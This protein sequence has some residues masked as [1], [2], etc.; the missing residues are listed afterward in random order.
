MAQN[1]FSSVYLKENSILTRS[2]F[3]NRNKNIIQNEIEKQI[4][5]V[6]FI[7]NNKSWYEFETEFSNFYWIRK[8]RWTMWEIEIRKGFNKIQKK[9]RYKNIPEEYIEYI[10]SLKDDKWM[11]RATIKPDFQIIIWK[12]KNFKERKKILLE[13][14]NSKKW[15]KKKQNSLYL[16]ETL[17][18]PNSYEWIVYI[19]NDSNIFHRDENWVLNIWF[20]Y[21]LENNIDTIEKLTELI[22]KENWTFT[23]NEYIHYYKE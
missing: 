18:N 12:D 1:I 17:L 6:N 10:K 21:I 22:L 5:K 11:I 20:N 4:K 3:L 19:I 13:I 8:T 15:K 7:I 2:E 9:L 14:K 16:L 23:W